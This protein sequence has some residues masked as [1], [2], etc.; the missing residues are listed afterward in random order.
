[1]G[2]RSLGITLW[3][4]VFLRHGYR[5][6]F[7]N[8]SGGPGLLLNLHPRSSAENEISSQDSEN[9]KI[10]HDLVQSA[11]KIAP[12]QPPRCIIYHPEG[13]RS[14][15]VSVDYSSSKAVG[16]AV[17]CWNRLVAPV[18]KRFGPSRAARDASALDREAVL[19]TRG[20]NANTPG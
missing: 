20:R 1:M 2:A 6:A 10:V 4:F 13:Q 14:P 15:V 3:S 19:D 16:D 17:V 8:A 5:T 7:E 12:T 9:F 11:A 18:E